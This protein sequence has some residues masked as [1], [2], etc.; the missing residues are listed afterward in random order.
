VGPSGGSGLTV[1]LAEAEG[2]LEELRRCLD[3][4]VE[5]IWPDCLAR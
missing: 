4:D 1:D 2:A 3:V 5:Q